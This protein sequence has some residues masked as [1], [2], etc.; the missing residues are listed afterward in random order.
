MGTPGSA[1]I[2]TAFGNVSCKDNGLAASFYLTAFGNV[3]CKDNGL[4]ASFYCI[5]AL[6]RQIR[7]IRVL[8]LNIRENP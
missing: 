7:V 3:S 1:V 5:S 4:A 6:I 8:F 2:L